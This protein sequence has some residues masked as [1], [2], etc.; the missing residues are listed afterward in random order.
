MSRLACPSVV[1][2][3]LLVAAPGHALELVWSSNSRN[4][5][6]TAATQCTLLVRTSS[7]LE[8]LPSDWQL[9]YV[10]E[11]GPG[12]RFLQEGPAE[13]VA[14]ACEIERRGLPSIVGHA[15]RITHCLPASGLQTRL[16]RYVIEF[17]GPV[18]AK[19]RIHIP[20]QAPAIAPEVSVNE[21][22]SLPY[23]PAI[24][25]AARTR[26]GEEVVVTIS[27]SGLENA[28]FA[29]YWSLTGTPLCTFTILRSEP[30]L[31]IVRA[32]L[33]WSLPAGFLSVGTSGGAISAHLMPAEPTSTPSDHVPGVVLMRF[34]DYELDPPPGR[35]EGSVGEFLYHRSSNL[36]AA[37][38]S[39]GISR[40]E[41]LLPRRNH[42]DTLAIGLH[43][44]QVV[45]EDL[46]NIYRA[47][48]PPGADL[49]AIIRQLRQIPGVL[50]AQRDVYLRATVTPNDP[51]YP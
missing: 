49:Q 33:P 10:A 8:P 28:Q 38:S 40:L 29:T 3:L 27:G 16:A 30:T 37:L 48:V 12:P 9:L 36:A 39:A 20:G 11:D 7:P 19:L 26:N 42:S 22:T 5:T 25:R 34:R 15:D 18:R 6:I 31:L 4:I 35:T 47:R 2:L 43:G 23:P 1:V 51:L 50:Y 17:A 24:D 44:E 41:R 46:A 45:L 32:A 21:G 14:V 13:T